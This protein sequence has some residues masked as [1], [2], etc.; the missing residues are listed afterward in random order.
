[1]KYKL[2]EPTIKTITFEMSVPVYDIEVEDDH[3]YCVG[4]E[5]MAVHNCTTYNTTG[6]GSP[7]FSASYNCSR[8]WKPSLMDYPINPHSIFS[9]GFKNHKKYVNKYQKLNIPIIADGGIRETQDI[10]KAL[11][12][13]AS[14]VMVGS[15]FV[16]CIDSPAD[17]LLLE[18]DKPRII[19]KNFDTGDY[20]THKIYFG[21]ASAKN[22]GSDEYVEG[23]DEVILKCNGLTYEKYYKKIEQAIQ[24]CMSYH[25]LRDMT[26]MNEIQWS[27][28]DMK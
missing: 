21:S 17:N 28:H 3:S 11:V 13:G 22:K 14:M 23:V 8:K 5:S 10:N 24:S 4:E 27:I 20:L 19:Y 6:V 25:N 12:A 1:M 7:M 16:K 9:E 15:E 18:S 26:K 2:L